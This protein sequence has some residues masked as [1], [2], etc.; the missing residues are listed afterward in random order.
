MKLASSNGA[1]AEVGIAGNARAIDWA[2]L[3][4]LAFMRPLA[5]RSTTVAVSVM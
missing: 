2:A 5:K 1:I 3:A 4:K